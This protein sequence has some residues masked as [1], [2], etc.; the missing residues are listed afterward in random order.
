M[1]YNLLSFLYE[2]LLM[3]RI[4][5]FSFLHFYKTNSRLISYCKLPLYVGVILIPKYASNFSLIKST[6]LFVKSIE[7]I[8]NTNTVAIFIEFGRGIKLSL[9]NKI[10]FYHSL[11]KIHK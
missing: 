11:Y 3:G 8:N 4:V 6:T 7:Y 2:K 9:K 1:F 5:V 10:V